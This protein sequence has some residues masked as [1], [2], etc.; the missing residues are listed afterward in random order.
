MELIPKKDDKKL[1]ERLKYEQPFLVSPERFIFHLNNGDLSLEEA[2]IRDLANEMAETYLNVVFFD[3]NLIVLREEESI[4]MSLVELTKHILLVT[5][6]KRLADAL[7]SY[8]YSPNAMITFKD[9][10][11]GW[12]LFR[13][14][15]NHIP[16]TGQDTLP[17][18]VT[19]D[20]VV[21]NPFLQSCARFAASDGRDVGFPLRDLQALNDDVVFALKDAIK[22]ITLRRT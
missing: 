8:G 14:G 4:A 2:T 21:Q 10:F 6:L 13:G 15:N 7:V 5:S 12:Y 22:E 18:D 16:L 20:E 9:G 11:E 1:R 19:F 3:D 17:F